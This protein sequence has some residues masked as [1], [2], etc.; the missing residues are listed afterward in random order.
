MSVAL[1]SLS[2]LAPKGSTLLDPAWLA[3]LGWTDSA[4][5]CD[6]G[7]VIPAYLDFDPSL[8]QELIERYPAARAVMSEAAESMDLSLGRLV[9]LCSPCFLDPELGRDERLARF[10]L[11]RSA[12]LALVTALY[13]QFQSEYALPVRPAVLLGNSWGF[14]A[15]LVLSGAVDLAGARQLLCAWVLDAAESSSE[16]LVALELGAESVE[17][18]EG[19]VEV[20]GELEIFHAKWSPTDRSRLRVS[21]SGTPR[22]VE[23]ALAAVERD[24]RF[25]EPRSYTPYVASPFHTPRVG[26]DA[27]R[28]RA[29][30]ACVETRDPALPLVCGRSDRYLITTAAGVREELEHTLRNPV[31]WDRME[32]RAQALGVSRF[33]VLA[34]RPV[35]A[36]R[37]AADG[38]TRCERLLVESLAT[39][40]SAKRALLT[41]VGLERP[42]VHRE[43]M[44]A[45]LVEAVR[46]GAR[47]VLLDGDSGA[48]KSVLCRE[49]R[50]RLA[51]VGIQALHLHGGNFARPGAFERLE[52]ELLSAEGRGAVPEV[53]ELT[54]HQALAALLERFRTLRRG[55]SQTI[56]IDGAYLEKESGREPGGMVEL[57]P[58]DVLLLEGNVTMHADIAPFLDL[59]MLVVV[60]RGRD[61]DASRVVQRARGRGRG[62][63]EQEDVY[64]RSV[65]C[66]RRPLMDRHIAS[67]IHLFD[68]VL[69]N[70]EPEAPVLMAVPGC[71]GPALAGALE[72]AALVA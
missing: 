49:L 22:A 37:A 57:G 42:C 36:P 44:V 59:A 70:S 56:T 5:P 58:D 6:H 31:R 10:M 1:A 27:H 26:A 3:Q 72:P 52:Q 34:R 30:L 8:P 15:G 32:K 18:V 67:T 7:L 33:L 11:N 23:R 53:L 43:A 55:S 14:F 54:D 69:D 71:E 19:A 63:R 60:D 28:L 68:L 4:V 2:P 41:G 9:E 61:I 45:Q 16:E 62:G 64:R 35:R 46:T 21:L 38:A 50:A 13:A 65:R 25:R 29:A 40:R 20:P 48:G 12:W 24:G 39:S 17:L 51:A 47:I 66:Y